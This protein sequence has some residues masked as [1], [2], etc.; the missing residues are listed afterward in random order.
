MAKE[1]TVMFWGGQFARSLHISQARRQGQVNARLLSND[2]K[3]TQQLQENPN[4]PLFEFSVTSGAALKSRLVA[5][6]IFVTLN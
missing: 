3:H 4:L 6:I 1:G 2:H 5:V